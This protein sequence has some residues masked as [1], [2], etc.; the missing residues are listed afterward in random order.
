[1]GDDR[2]ETSDGFEIA[3]RVWGGD[4]TGSD[5]VLQHGY[6]ANGVTN[7]ELPGVVTALV[8]DGHRV[9][10]PDALGHGRSSTPH[11]PAVYGEARVARDLVELFDHLALDAVR[12]A[13][14][15]M[16]AIVALLATSMDRRVRRLVVGG[17]GRGVVDLGGVDRD[18]LHPDR[19]VEALEV[20]DPA[21]LPEGQARSFRLFA[22]GTGGDRLALV[23]PRDAGWWFV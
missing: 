6:I 10:A 1:M 9:I 22:D 7:W 23:P 14:Y 20:D 11:D 13:G 21:S 17:I 15:S 5:V 12:L 3:Y 2:F 18:V 8:D 4:N 19:L 16:G